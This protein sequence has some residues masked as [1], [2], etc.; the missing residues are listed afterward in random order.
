MLL[1][2]GCTSIS[3]CQHNIKEEKKGLPLPSD[4]ESMSDALLMR[5]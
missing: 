2:L 1:R 5:T 3:L 4:E